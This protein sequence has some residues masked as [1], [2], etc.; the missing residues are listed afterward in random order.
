[1]AFEFTAPINPILSNYPFLY[2]PCI[3]R[4]LFAIALGLWISDNLDLFA[5]RNGAII[6]GSVVS[7]IYLFWANTVMM[8]SLRIPWLLRPSWLQNSISFCYACL[9]IL[10]GLKFLP[11]K[12]SNSI[13]KIFGKIG[14]ESYHIFLMQLI[15]FSSINYQILFNSLLISIIFNIVFCI[16]LGTLFYSFDERLDSCFSNILARFSFNTYIHLKR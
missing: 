13:I 12:S 16:A 10:V 9:L 2:S 6:V 1:M 15:F 7:A 4:Y 8:T 11:S 5:P 3:L 14:I